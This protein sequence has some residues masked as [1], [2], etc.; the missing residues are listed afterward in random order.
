MSNKHYKE[1]KR[2]LESSENIEKN[3][4]F[5]IID[6]IEERLKE[7]ENEKN[8]IE[9]L[10]GIDENILNNYLSVEENITKKINSKKLIEKNNKRKYEDLGKL[11]F[12]KLEEKKKI[13]RTPGEFQKSL[14][15]EPNLCDLLDKSEFE[16]KFYSI[17]ELKTKPYNVK[18]FDINKYNDYI[19]N[20]YF[21]FHLK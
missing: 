19:Y 10:Y 4:E 13:Y 18:K 7:L 1:L 14:K 3:K 6:Q 17:D 2:K 9:N 21:N 16:P 12:T 11:E 20:E 15:Y 8:K 5:G